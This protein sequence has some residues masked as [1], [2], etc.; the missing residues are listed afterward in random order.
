[1]GA[2]R[3]GSSKLAIVAA[4]TSIALTACAQAATFEIGR[5][6]SAMTKNGGYTDKGCT[7]ENATHAGRYEWHPG[8]VKNGFTFTSVNGDLKDSAAPFATILCESLSGRG[9]VGTPA[10][11]SGLVLRTTHCKE[12]VTNEPLCTSPGLNAGE[13][14]TTSLSLQLGMISSSPRVVGIALT[15]EEG[16]PFS[17]IGCPRMTTLWGGVITRLQKVNVMLPAARPEEILKYKAP[18]EKG[19]QEF[20]QFEGMAPD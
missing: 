12:S 2:G 8:L 7:S 4:L 18:H 10:T 13:V 14:E 15:P 9:T 20:S 11:L 6:V 1:M 5:C 17:A 3:E 19:L 16:D